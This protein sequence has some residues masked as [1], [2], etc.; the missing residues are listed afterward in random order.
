M[1]IDLTTDPTFV[2]KYQDAGAFFTRD[3]ES[4]GTIIKDNPSFI[5]SAPFT[6]LVVID[7]DFVS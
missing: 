5:I 1:Y 4:P 3:T 7:E 2:S 6:A